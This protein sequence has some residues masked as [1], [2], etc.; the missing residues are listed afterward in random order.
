MSV[1]RR[2]IQGWIGSQPMPERERGWCAEMKRINPTWTHVLFGNEVLE[3]Y[4]RDPYVKAMQDTKRPMA[5]IV[6][7]IRALMLAEGGGVWLDPD[8]Q[9]IRPLDTLKN[10]WDAPEVEFVMG[11]RN[12]HRSMVA[13]HRGVT[14][15][16]NTIMASAPNSRMIRRILNLWKPNQV[17]VDGH[18]TGVEMLA[19]I[20]GYR[21]RL[22]GFRYFYDLQ[23]NPEAIVLHDAHNMGSWVPQIKA[24]RERMAVT[25]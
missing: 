5:F 18:A 6:D 7:R 4:A 11:L 2:I 19:Q 15:C 16:D 17:V 25:Q 24:E 23:D 21:E 8:C 3:R 1:P 14:L 10:I 13:L 20:D 12:P 9:P 22:V